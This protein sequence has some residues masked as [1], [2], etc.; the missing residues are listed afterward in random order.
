MSK[1]SSCN[2]SRLRII[3]KTNT[4]LLLVTPIP[5]ITNHGTSDATI[6]QHGVIIT[7]FSAFKKR[8]H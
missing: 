2:K 8:V 6:R 5:A 4:E 3:E 1:W 7:A